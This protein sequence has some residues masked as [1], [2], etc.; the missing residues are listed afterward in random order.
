M[1]A[2][3]FRL[4][5]QDSV[6]Q[7]GEYENQAR[8]QESHVTVKN[9]GQQR[10]DR[11]PI[12]LQRYD[13][14]VLFPGI[15]IAGQQR[16]AQSR[17]VVIG[18]GAL[19]TVSSNLL[20]RAG[21]G[22]LTLV[23][24]DFV[25]LNNLQ[26]QVLFEEADVGWPKAVV[27]ARVL[28]RV[29]ST[30]Q[31]QEHVADVDFRNIESFLL[32]PRRTDLVI[33]G[34]DNFDVRFLINDACVKHS[35]PWI[36]AGCLGA[37]GQV[38]TVL[39]G[40]TACLHCLISEGPPPPGTTATCDTAGI[41]A[42]MINVAAA[43]QVNEGLKILAGQ[44]SAL[45]RQLLVFDLWSNR[46]Q[47][48]DIADLRERSDCPTCRH[49]QFSWL[50]GERGSQPVILCGRNAVQVS[51]AQRTEV[52]LGPLAARWKTAGQ[53]EENAW[54]VRLHV[55]PYVITAFR[56]GRAI[57]SGTEDISLAKKLYAQYVG[58]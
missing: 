22:Q 34:T 18:C 52:P 38:M 30:I 35:I 36:Y 20:V 24:R 8:E 13:R 19:G 40:E 26:R 11:L 3:T 16:L 51:V 5:L 4:N 45:N 47:A 44:K 58:G 41:L 53:V 12:E 2:R 15:G 7:T 55:D 10:S 14:Q 54:L 32:S 57:V 23:D 17:V 42:S 33:D 29:N 56:D 50:N 28:R 39:P 27:A 9:E 37:G 6:V 46:S 43:Y 1:P 49:H 48:M 21:I 25:E 31:I